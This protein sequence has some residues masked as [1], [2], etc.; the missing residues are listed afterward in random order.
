[1]RCCRQFTH[2]IRAFFPVVVTAILSGCTILPGMSFDDSNAQFEPVKGDPAVSPIIKTIT[3]QL[4]Q[5]EQQLAEA[6]I[7]ADI[8]GIMKPSQPYK[9][10]V[11]D[12]LAITVWDHPEL[13]MPVASGYTVSDEGR[14]QFPYAGDFKVE[15][16]DEL[17]ARDL[18]IQR[19]SNVIKKPEVTLRVMNYRSKRVYMDGEVKTPGIVHIDDIPLTLPEA[20]NRAGGVTAQGDQSRISITRA[21]K[22]YWVDMTRLMASGI[23][24]SRIMLSNGDM[25]RVSPRE[26]SKVYVIG[27]VSKHVTLA[28]RNGRLNLNEALGEAGGV[29][30][31]SADARQIYVIRNT[32]DAK[33]LVYHLNGRSPVMLALAENFWLKA[34]DV[35]YVDGAPMVRFNRVLNLI[36]PSAQTIT[37]INRRLQ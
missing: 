19:L 12:Q 27:E 17:Q 9:I 8:S 35:V 26:E 15:G 25:L 1:M 37:F 34:G 7:H 18:L 36:L 21:N 22:T 24:P 20:I 2:L 23:D 3:P 16:L 33:P 14:I 31:M 5:E 29:N 30:P 10:G 11:G 6:E 4:I 13:S 28:L 32:N